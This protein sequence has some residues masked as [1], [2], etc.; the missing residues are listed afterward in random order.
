MQQVNGSG[1]L[2]LDIVEVL[3]A[4]PQQVYCRSVNPATLLVVAHGIVANE[5]KVFHKGSKGSV[6]QYSQLLSHALAGH[7][8]LDDIEVVWGDILSDRGAKEALWI[9]LLKE[10]DDVL[11]SSKMLLL[12]C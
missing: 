8:V 5:L 7:R 12:S 11:Q 3:L 9:L 4:M 6:V 2:E 10:A 1:S